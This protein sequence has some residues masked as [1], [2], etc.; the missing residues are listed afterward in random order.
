MSER[1]ELTL[2]EAI[3]TDAPAIIALWQ[4]CGLT[5]PW[6]DPQADFAQAIAGPTSTVLVVEQEQ[7]FAGSVMVGFDGHRGWVY[8]L[9][10]AP[11]HR[12]NGLGRTL[13]DS[14]EVW[15]RARGAPKIQLMVRDDN[16]AA[17]GFYEAL[18]LERQKVVTLGKFLKD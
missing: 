13:M 11:V 7:A 4:A 9:A 18:G 16:H 15:L 8:Y 12:R 2:R 3:P 14:A 5:R 6:N 17:L 1:L 10:V